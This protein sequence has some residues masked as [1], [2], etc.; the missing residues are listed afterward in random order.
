[1]SLFYDRSDNLGSTVASSSIS[2][3]TPV[4]GSRVSFESSLLSKKYL[5]GYYR[6]IPSSLNNLVAKFDM[7]YDVKSSDAQEIVRCVEKIMMDNKYGVSW[8]M[9]SEFYQNIKVECK[10]YAINHINKNHYEVAV[11]LEA[12]RGCPL[13]D[14]K[15]MSYLNFTPSAFDSGNSYQKYDVCRSGSNGVDRFYYATQNS[16]GSFSEDNW[17]QEFFFEADIG[18]QNEVNMNV[19]TIG[20]ENSFKTYNASQKHISALDLSYKFTNLT[21][22][23]AKCLLHFLESKAGYRRFKHQPQSIYTTRPKVF[24][25]P[26]WSH[27]FKYY[28]SHDIDVRLIEDPLGVIPTNQ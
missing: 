4:Y 6:N 1:M 3:W 11:S 10:N 2:D 13:L 23:Q 18:M 12:N 8:Q 28:N 21:D 27:T 25:C 19:E 22:D 15:T 20:F 24:F 16:S 17:T 9:P 14:W 7:R 5:D 26:S